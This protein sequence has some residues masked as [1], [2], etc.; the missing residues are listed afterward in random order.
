MRNLLLSTVTFLVV[1]AV[2]IAASDFSSKPHTHT[3]P[4]ELKPISSSSGLK[5]AGVCFLGAGDC[6]DGG[7]GSIDGDDFRSMSL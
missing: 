2:A 5:L 6:G 1:P 7:F 4:I 3:T